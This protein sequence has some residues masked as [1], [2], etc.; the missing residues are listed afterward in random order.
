VL[1]IQLV[2]MATR[3][4]IGIP[5]IAALSSL[6]A[7][8]ATPVNAALQAGLL[9]REVRRTGIPAHVLKL[10]WRI[11][12]AAGVMGGA[13]WLLNH[14]LGIWPLI[15]IGAAIY[16]AGLIVL[17]AFPAEDIRTLRTLLPARAA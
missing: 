12:L 8:I 2:V 15:P 9:E 7:A 13:C 10:G 17:R 4:A 6:G 11:G 3:L 5:I 14:W 1:R 16:L